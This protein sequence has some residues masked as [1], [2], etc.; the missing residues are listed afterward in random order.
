MDSSCGRTN[1]LVVTAVLSGDNQNDK[2]THLR[3]R[4]FNVF[5]G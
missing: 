2:H 3:T 4:I 5:R 1:H